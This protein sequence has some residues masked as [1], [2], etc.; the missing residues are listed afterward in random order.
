MTVG[1]AVAAALVW[2]SSASAAHD[3]RLTGTFTMRGK[4]TRASHVRGERRGMHV[5]R[6]WSFSSSC[7]SGPCA[8]VTLTRGRSGGADTLVLDRRANGVYG[9]SSSFVIPVL[10][11]G[12]RIAN[13]ARVDFAVV[14]RVL[15]TTSVQGVP[16]ATSVSATYTN[17]RRVNLTSCP[18]RL[19]RDAARYSGRSS[20]P[21]PTP[22]SAAFNASVSDPLTSTDQF[23][24]TS[25][26]GSGG[27]PIVAWSWDFGDPG[28]GAANSSPEANPSHSFSSH[29]N[30]TVTLTVRDANGLVATVR[31]TVSS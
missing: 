8:Q 31:Q 7:P 28:S 4:I 19:G 6:R 16:F 21:P 11:K 22:P 17:S 30:H 14:V 9:G 10:C 29:G 5:T 26:P 2:T 1:V 3:A 15:R 20:T 13:G 23:Q 12:A 25:R 27:A 24:D 18:G